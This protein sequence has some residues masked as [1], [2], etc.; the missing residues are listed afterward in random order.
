MNIEKIELGFRS[1][2]DGKC[3]V[4]ENGMVSTAFPIATDAGVDMLQK[5]GNA[6]DA[7]CAAALSLCVCEPQACGLGGQTMSLIHMNHRTVA[8]DGSGPAPALFDI[9]KLRDEDLQIG[10]RGTT[11]PTT[12]AVI[13]HMHATYGRLKWAIVVEPAIQ[14]ARNGYMITRLQHKLQKRELPLFKAVF[15]RSGARYFLNNRDDPMDVGLHFL[16]PEL[17]MVLE[18]IAEHG[19][20]AFYSGRIANMIDADMKANGGFLRAEDLVRIPW[21]KELSPVRA[22]YRNLEIASSPPPM[23]GRNLLFILRILNQFPSYKV[24]VDTPESAHRLIN[25]FKNVLKLR[26]R[27][28]VSSKGYKQS[29]DPL[30]NDRRLI[31]SFIQMLTYTKE[32]DLTSNGCGIING[33]TTHLSVMDKEGN[34]VG[35]TQS[36]NM[37]YG[38]KAVAE[39]LGFLYNNYLLDTEPLDS[40]HPHFLHSG[41]F[42]WSFACPTI[43]F[44][45]G[46]PWIVT[47]SPGSERI[48]STISQFL[49]NIIDGDLPIC[50]AM[51]LPRLHCS[52][53]G[54]VSLESDRFDPNIID[55]LKEKGHKIESLEPYSF[56]LGAVHAVLKRRTEKGFQG[57]AEI[58]RDGTAKGG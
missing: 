43:V 8:L 39:G 1:T 9:A 2:S 17:A 23:S 18:E 42:P 10:Y 52:A 50:E 3:A 24:P 12:P 31:N 48:L 37:V 41:G 49:I 57:V 30:L 45:E 35:I 7:A 38:S 29:D 19:V 13:G 34:A 36:V 26:D 44:Y 20:K 47:G 14:I 55:Y 21:P 40:T 33:E 27:Q 32:S 28:L 58:R 11:I 46:K 54:L 25:I 16:Q 53:E 4:A 51:Q 56:Y 5:G 22:Q 15:P 6:V